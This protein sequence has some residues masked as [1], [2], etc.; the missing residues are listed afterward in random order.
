MNGCLYR[1]SPLCRPSALARNLGRFALLLTAAGL[2][3]GCSG[4]HISFLDPQ[5]PVAEAQSNH[6]W[7]VI[8]LCMVVVLPVILLTPI[9]I[10]RYRYGG[11]GA[12]R[13]HVGLFPPHGVRHLGMP[14][15]IVVF[16]SV[17]LWVRP[18]QLDPYKP[19]SG[20]QTT[21]GGGGRV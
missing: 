3:A 14:M 18:T 11:N 20:R 19:I 12:Y 4:E 13:P 8:G 10:W 9:I 21:E 1:R 16:L 17:F 7:L 2:L 6:F 15:L 5:G